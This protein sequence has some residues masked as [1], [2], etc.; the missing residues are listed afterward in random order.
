VIALERHFVSTD[1][2]RIVVLCRQIEDLTREIAEKEEQFT[3]AVQELHRLTQTLSLG[4]YDGPDRS[5]LTRFTVASAAHKEANRKGDLTTR[6]LTFL[7]TN[8][9][10]S[11]RTP[12]IA[13]ALDV[14][15]RTKAVYMNLFRLSRRGRIRKTAEGFAALA[16]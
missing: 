13:E 11:F 2:N 7:D 14:P 3:A 12:A 4:E 16:E 1:R 9:G 10:Q 6:I 15:H 8:G 5:Q